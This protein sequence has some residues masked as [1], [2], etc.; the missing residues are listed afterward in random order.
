MA[1]SNIFLGWLGMVLRVTIMEHLLCTM[2][3]LVGVGH[4]TKISFTFRAGEFG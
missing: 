2:V 1:V 3:F 4:L